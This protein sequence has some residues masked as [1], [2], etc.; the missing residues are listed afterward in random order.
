MRQ[1]GR[2]LRVADEPPDR[3]VTGPPYMSDAEAARGH[4]GCGDRPGVDDC[5]PADAGGVEQPCDLGADPARAA[6]LDPRLP[7]RSHRRHTTIERA[8]QQAESG[9]VGFP[10]VASS[11]RAVRLVVVGLGIPIQPFCR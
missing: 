10:R 1:S 6:D 5:C 4:V 7:T 9:L 8:G 11:V 3:L 2:R